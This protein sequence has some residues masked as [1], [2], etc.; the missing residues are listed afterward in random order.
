MFSSIWS[1]IKREFSYGNM[2]TRIII[3]NVVVYIA[4][5]LMWMIMKHTNGG[6][7]P[8]LYHDILHFFCMSSDWMYVLTHPWVILTNM[9]LHEGFRHIL[10]NMLFLYWFGRI[11]GDL[12]GNQRVLPLYLLGGIAGAVIFF[13]SANL[14]PY[15]AG[16]ARFALGASGAVMAIIVASGVIAPDYNFRLLFIGDVKLKYVVAVLVLMDLVLT[17]GDDN[18]G[19]HF[20]HLGGAAFGWFFVYRLRQGSDMAIPINNFIDKIYGFFEKFGKIKGP[21]VAYRN[22]NLKRK[23]R[24]HS[25]S[26]NDSE[27]TVS[28]QEQLDDILEKIKKS[29][30]DS[31]SQEEKEFLFDASKK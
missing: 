13:I 30:Y 25:V 20:A 12:L 31:L 10:F 18:T 17:A 24:P 16:G 8:A 14:M 1:D 26:D 3:V 29:G 9:F 23:Q 5:N 7:E 19:G 15:G 6:D 11:F 28:H 21:R 2:I 27:R 4:V 22:P